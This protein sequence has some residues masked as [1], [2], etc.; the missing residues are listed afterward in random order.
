MTAQARTD[1][2]QWP[3]PIWFRFGLTLAKLILPIL[4]GA[5]FLAVITPFG[6]AMRLLGRDPLR[7]K[8]DPQAKTYWITCTPGGAGPNSKKTRS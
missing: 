1:D 5:I 6:L 4:L 2:L 3:N 7:L 8:A